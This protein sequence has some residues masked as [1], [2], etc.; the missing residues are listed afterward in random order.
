MYLFKLDGELPQGEQKV[1]VDISVWWQSSES[2][3]PEQLSSRR[4][5][6]DIGYA[7]IL[8]DRVFRDVLV[9]A[10]ELL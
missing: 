8:T 6:V 3:F 2:D 5:T 9:A 7:T 4:L 1:A 10:A